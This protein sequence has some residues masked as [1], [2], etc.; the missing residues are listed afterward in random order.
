MIAK[1]IEKIKQTNAPICVG[2]DPLISHIPDYILEEKIK[3][4]KEKVDEELK[5]KNLDSHKIEWV[6]NFYFQVKKSWNYDKKITDFETKIQSKYD[7]FYSKAKEVFD[8][9]VKKLNG[10]FKADFDKLAEQKKEFE[11]NNEAEILS[12]T[13]AFKADKPKKN[14][15]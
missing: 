7:N 15:K 8:D 4:A 12:K 1:L 2:L 11:K 6:W 5:N 10:K 13:L 3:K 9:K 14:K